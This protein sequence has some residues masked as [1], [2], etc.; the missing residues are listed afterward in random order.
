MKPQLNHS[1]DIVPVDAKNWPLPFLH[2]PRLLAFCTGWPTRTWLPCTPAHSPLLHIPKGSSSEIGSI[3]NTAYG[4]LMETVIITID[5]FFFFTLDLVFPS[6]KPERM[7]Y[8]GL[9]G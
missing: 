6:L 9:L 4:C 7:F 5:F 2:L 3:T 1:R 8:V